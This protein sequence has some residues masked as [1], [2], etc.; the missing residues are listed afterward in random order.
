MYLWVPLPPGL[1]SAEFASR[2]LDE[3]GVV[4]LP[5]SAFGSG[6]EGF[7]RVALTVGVERLRVGIA[8][9]GQVLRSCR[10]A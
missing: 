7:F 9:L 2:A 6:G 8:R 1:R 3:Q 10:A 5:G 4:V